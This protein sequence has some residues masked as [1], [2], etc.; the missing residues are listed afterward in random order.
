[1]QTTR[2]TGADVIIVDEA[3]HI[4][5]ELF[6][7][8]IVPILQMKNTA[9]MCLSSPADDANY[10]SGMLTLKKKD[11]SDFFHVIDCFLICR[12][13]RK[14]ERVKQ[15]N[16]THVPSATPWLSQRKTRD[17]TALL[18]A[19]DTIRELAGGIISDHKPA[20]PKEEIARL[21]ARPT[22]ITTGT[23]QYIFTS[24]DPNGGGP[25]H[26]SIVSAYFTGAGG[27]NMVVIGMD[28]EPVGDDKDEYFLIHR[29]YKRL[30]EHR[31]WREAKCIFIPENNL[32]IESAHLD[33]MVRDIPGVRTYWEKPNKPGVLKDGRVTRAYQ[34]NLAHALMNE[35]IS[36]DADCFT[37]TREM[38]TAKMRDMLQEQMLRYHWEKKAALD[39]LGKD[40]YTL[41]GKIGNKQDDLLIAFAMTLYW[42][43]LA[44]VSLKQVQ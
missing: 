11:G 12:A 6:R 32:A 18:S 19:E 13:C 25:S 2:G 23:P 20:L 33:T 27:A 8:V 15:I 22:S 21:F 7:K 4:D 44:V 17:L 26:M 40:R 38:N 31:Y 24:C 37:V 29:H 5:P 36:F 10:Y 1:M 9:L 16:C 3:A 34:F 14:L 42:S 43:P 35:T 41:T 28:S 30:R 39:A